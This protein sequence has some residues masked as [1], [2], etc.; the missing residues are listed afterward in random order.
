M[1]NKELITIIIPV[2]NVYPYLAEA[3]DSVLRQTY[4]NLEII[5][6][7][8]GSSDGSGQLCDEYARRDNRVSVVHQENAGLSGARNTGLEMAT[9]AVIAF[10]DS[11]DAY[12][13]DC[14]KIMM[15]TM[16]REKVDIVVCDYSLHHTTGKM[17]QRNRRLNEEKTIYNRRDALCALADGYIDHHAWGKLYSRKLWEGIRYPVGRVYEDID[18]TYRVIDLCDKVCVL[19][20]LLYLHR[21]RSGSIAAICSE[22]N[23]RDSI[24]A[25]RHFTSFV[26]QHIPDVFTENNLLKSRR[27]WLVRMMD[28]YSRL[29]WKEKAFKKELKR[30]IL[31]FEGIEEIKKTDIPLRCACW[32]ISR[33]SW[34]FNTVY[35]VYRFIR[36]IT[37]KR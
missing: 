12:H 20:Q 33:C 25:N 21:K 19:S 31:Q 1:D 29:P 8:D 11:D 30:H 22:Q 2:Y 27:A 18:T 28:Y 36:H 9:G 14:I 6:I 3:I 5:I 15:S 7:D 23:I 13:P 35:P 4:D 32:M 17:V 24:I 37:W 34:L 10:L 26:S 16:V